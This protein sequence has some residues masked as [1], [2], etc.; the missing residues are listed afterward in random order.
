LYQFVWTISSLVEKESSHISENFLFSVASANSEN[1]FGP[2]GPC[3]GKK[4]FASL[5]KAV[6]SLF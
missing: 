6:V 2:M 5:K 1:F 4:A 3:P